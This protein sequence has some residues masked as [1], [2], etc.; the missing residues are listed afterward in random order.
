MLSLPEALLNPAV[1]PHAVEQVELIE[2]HL[3]WVFLTGDYVYKVKKP[4]HFDFVDFS[5]LARRRY[6]CTEEVR[7]NRAFAPELYL[8]VVAIVP[9]EASGDG[10]MNWV[11]QP[12]TDAN[13]GHALEYAVRMQQFDGALQ[14]DHLLAAGAL[15]PSEMRRFGARLASQHAQLP[16]LNRPYDAGEAILD[17]FTTLRGTAVGQTLP[18]I[19]Q[20]QDVAQKQLE[21]FDGLL[22]ARHAARCVR[23]CHGDLHLSNLARLQDGLTAFDCLEFDEDLRNIDFWC[24]AGFLF[25]DCCVRQ[26]EDLAY[27]FVDGY[28]DAGGDYQGVQLLPM[29]ADY[30][31]VVRAKIAA[32]RYEQTGA[33][34][35]QSRLLMHLDWPLH[36]QDR[37]LGALWVMCGLS[38]SGKSY[39]AERL[40]PTMPAIRLRSDVLRKATHGLDRLQPSGSEVGEGIYQAHHSAALYESL[41]QHA[42]PLLTQG[43]HVLVD[44][45]C[46]RQAQRQTLYDVAHAVGAKVHLI[47]CTAPEGLLR[48]RIQSR[49]QIGTD[50]SEAD[51]AV[52]DWQLDHFE[53]P[54]ADEPVVTVDTS[55]MSV[56]R[57]LQ[58]LHA[59]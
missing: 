43:E 7:C 8:G 56:E 42:A 4:V 48:K 18:Q 20:L 26:R 47:Y 25:M 9:A 14:A 53:L 17:N 15:E 19:Q 45:A 41:A 52:L 5:S 50:P 27:A 1:Y 34:E 59:D 33:D 21:T 29:F 31:S 58:L 28:L 22:K 38:G 40:V 54:G 3:S 49:A 44:A 46:L 36:R 57:L 6:F 55:A 39:W 12:L 32:L 37:P 2:T 30:R 10:A 23:E 35:D 11:V 13:Q 24:D 51:Q 16:V